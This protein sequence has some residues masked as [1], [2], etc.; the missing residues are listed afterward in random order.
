MDPGRGRWLN[1]LLRRLH[2]RLSSDRVCG[3]LVDA[4]D[5]LASREEAKSVSAV[6]QAQPP[7]S[8][9]ALLVRNGPQHQIACAIEVLASLRQGGELPIAARLKLQQLLG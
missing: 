9:V 3:V 5:Y 1:R 2:Q 6:L 4:P 8:R 7:G